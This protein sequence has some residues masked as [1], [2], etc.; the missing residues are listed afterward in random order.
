M[1]LDIQVGSKVKVID[2][3][4]KF[5]RRRGIVSEELIQCSLINPDEYDVVG[6]VCTL[7]KDG[8]NCIRVELKPGQV[9]RIE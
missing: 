7:H 1:K 6:F 5:Y 4:S 2:R 8:K 9:A 3:K